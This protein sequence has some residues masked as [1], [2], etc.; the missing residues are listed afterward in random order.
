M[1]TKQ[2]STREENTIVTVLTEILTERGLTVSRPEHSEIDFGKKEE[3]S[4]WI[5]KATVPDSVDSAMDEADKRRCALVPTIVVYVTEA[6]RLTKPE[7]I[8]VYAHMV[9]KNHQN[10]RN[11]IFVGPECCMRGQRIPVVDKDDGTF[12]QTIPKEHLMFNVLKHSLVP[13]HEPMSLQA[14]QQCCGTNDMMIAK[15]FVNALPCVKL[16][17]PVTVLLGGVPADFGLDLNGIGTVYKI[18]RYDTSNSIACRKVVYDVG[19]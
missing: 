6:V 15:N 3:H 5:M 2:P 16:T 7:K 17:D 10:F 11:I 12:V 14:I 9:K 13:K 1:A 4:R 19:L 18:R 8:L